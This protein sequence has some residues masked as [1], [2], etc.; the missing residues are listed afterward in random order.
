MALGLAGAQVHPMQR[1]P[2]VQGIH[3]SYAFDDVDKAGFDID[4]KDRDNEHKPLY[5]LKCHSGL[6]DADKDF[7][8]SGLIDCRLV[9]LYS[10][11]TASSLLADKSPQIS[12]WSDRGRFL[13]A[14]LRKGC[15]VYPDWGQ[16]R[17]FRLRGMEITIAISNVTFQESSS[18]EDKVQSYSVDVTVKSDPTASTSLAQKPIT[19]EPPWFFHPTQSCDQ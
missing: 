3:A 1:W 11:E 12:D 16:R 4:F 14:H 2:Q 17:I 19:P 9:S 18:G 5:V 6:Y 10:R 13:S 8:Y 15:A 7:D